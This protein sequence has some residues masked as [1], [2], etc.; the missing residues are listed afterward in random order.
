MPDLVSGNV[1]AVVILVAE[2]ASD[3][4]YASAPR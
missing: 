3:L 2:R 4:I 1:N